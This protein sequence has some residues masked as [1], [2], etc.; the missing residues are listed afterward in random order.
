MRDN[1]VVEW[2]QSKYENLVVDLNERARRRWAAVE[3][4]SL[5]RGGIAAVAKATGISDRTIRNGIRELRKGDTPPAGRQRRVGGGLDT[6]VVALPGTA[7]LREG[8]ASTYPHY[9]RQ[10]RQQW[11]S[12]PA[13]EIRTAKTRGQTRRRN[14][15]MP[16]STR[17]QQV[18]QNR[19]SSVLSYHSHLAWRTVAKL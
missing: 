8:K 1:S 18:E 2:I 11:A 6:N 19:A 15:G 17:Y 14:G 10:R 13:L 4:L 12:Q 3:A 9:G 5:G 16:L 7:T